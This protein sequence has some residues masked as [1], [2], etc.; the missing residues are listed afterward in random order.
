L[1]IREESVR[2]R[3]PSDLSPR[4]YSRA[5]YRVVWFWLMLWGTVMGVAAAISARVLFPQAQ[6]AGPF[7]FKGTCFLAGA[8]GVGAVAYY[9]VFFAL[10][11]T[12]RELFLACAFAA[13]ATSGVLQAI[14]NSSLADRLYND[15]LVLATWLFA[16]LLF[17][18]AAHARSRLPRAGLASTALQLLVG[19]AIVVAYPVVLSFYAFYPALYDSFHG[20][21]NVLPAAKMDCII[22]LGAVLLMAAAAARSFICRSQDVA[23]LDRILS[24]FQVAG[25]LGLICRAEAASVVD[26]WWFSGQVISGLAWL[27]LAIG[28]A[29]ESAFTHR[30]LVERLGELQ[31]LH[32]LS[33][34]LVGTGAGDFFRVFVDTLRQKVDVELAAVYL[35]GSTGVS[36]ELAA[37]SG[38]DNTYPRVG[39][40]YIIASEDRRPGFHTGHTAEA[41]RS[42]E[43]RVADDVSIDVEFVPWRVI[44]HGDGRA[45]SLPLIEQGAVYGVLNVYFRQRKQLDRQGLA[46]LKT[47]AAAAGPAIAGVWSERQGSE[48]SQGQLDQAA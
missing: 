40:T 16:A 13:L 1:G 10:N 28:F 21:P 7:I 39:T 47:I 18:G 31:A 38:G 15:R 6:F 41:Y 24:Y 45:V 48:L 27:L 3:L 23:R 19:V 35:A 34:S 17:L 4:P 30:E 37:V 12:L 2:S 9:L 26:I 42:K 20:S 11:R 43:M 14:S 8:M 44:A 5:R 32:D 33:W 22:A 29:A 46:F 36:L 25:G